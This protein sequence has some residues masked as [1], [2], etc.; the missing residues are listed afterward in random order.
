MED[1]LRIK[2]LARYVEDGRIKV[3][4]VGKYDG[5]FL[6]FHLAKKIPL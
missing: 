4:S 5:I 3:K 2:R 1:F 6:D